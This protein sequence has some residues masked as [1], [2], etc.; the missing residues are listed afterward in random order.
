MSA[1]TILEFPNRL[2]ELRCGEC[3][4][5]FAVLGFWLGAQRASGEGGGQFW[6]P[7]GHNGVFQEPEVQRLKRLLEQEQKNHAIT[8]QEHEQAIA[9][10]LRLQRQVA[11]VICPCCKRSFQNL[12]R[13]M[14]TKHPQY[15]NK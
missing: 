3:G 7:N 11:R 15:A 4:I 6:C 10:T 13:H 2:E 12:L 8:K 1:T 14:K 5:V 9:E